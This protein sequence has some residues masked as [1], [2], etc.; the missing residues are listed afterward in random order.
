MSAMYRFGPFRD[1]TAGSNADLSVRGQ[2]LFA[3]ANQ[4]A[5]D[6]EQWE[7]ARDLYE[8]CVRDSPRYAPA[9]AR[10]ARCHRVIA[11]STPARAVREH[12]RAEAIRAFEQALALDPDLPL[13]HILYAQL[14]VDLGMAQEAMVRL[15]MVLHRHGPNADAYA[16]LVH[17]LRWCGLVQESRAA[18]ERARE[19]DPA[20]IT[21]VAQTSWLLG[22]FETA[23]AETARDAGPGLGDPEALYYTARTYAKLGDATAA[24]ET[25][26][27]VLD[28]GYVCLPALLHDPWLAR[29]R[30][31]GHLEPLIERARSQHERAREVFL[32]AEGDRLLRW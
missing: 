11:K 1:D 3:R 22:D 18:H 25:L 15:L 2:E 12:G 4:L 30:E 19:L 10:L 7:A 27:R 28:Y 13:A 26:A 32:D 9:W 29:L 16:G 8:A 24:L 23:L 31:S 20:V 17:A 5:D 6:A 14:E 21:T